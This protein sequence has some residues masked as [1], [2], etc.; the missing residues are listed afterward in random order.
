MYGLIAAVTGI[1]TAGFAGAV[2]QLVVALF[3]RTLNSFPS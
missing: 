2:G 3:E 1:A